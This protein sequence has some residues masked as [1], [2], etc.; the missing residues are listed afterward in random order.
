MS[1][2]SSARSTSYSARSIADRAPRGWPCTGDGRLSHRKAEFEQF[3]MNARGTPQQVLH[4][5]PADQCPQIH[6][7][8]HEDCL[9][10]T[11]SVVGWLIVFPR[12]GTL[13]TS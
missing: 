4:A 3:T 8:E 13:V 2:R 9:C 12:T 6:G 7:Q 11:T 1:R 10:P 5:H